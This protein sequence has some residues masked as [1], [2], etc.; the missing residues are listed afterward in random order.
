MSPPA[1]DKEKYRD[2]LCE[3]RDEAQDAY[4]KA[5]LTLSA[6]GLGLAIG[7]VRSEAP[8]QYLVLFMTACASFAAALLSMVYS[9]RVSLRSY[10]AALAELNGQ[11]GKGSTYRERPSRRHAK[12]TERLNKTAFAFLVVGIVSLGTFVAVNLGRLKP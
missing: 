4:D 3:G 12:S 11:G 2:Q 8:P 7:L 6:G 10:D 1:E 5:I 9:F